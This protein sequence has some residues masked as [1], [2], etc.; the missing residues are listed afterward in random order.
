MHTKCLPGL[1]VACMALT[2]DNLGIAME[3][4]LA[5]PFADRCSPPL[6]PF[7][8]FR[9]AQSDTLM[10][11]DGA[12]IDLVCQVNL[13]ATGLRWTL[14]RNLFAKPFRGGRAAPLLAN[15][16]AIAIDTAG[17]HPGFYDVQV[18]V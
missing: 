10:F 14:H 17:L 4:N 13:R 16:F 15:R 9:S 3:H 6:N 11:S 18:E 5:L 8:S 1:L 12:R 2:C 7:I